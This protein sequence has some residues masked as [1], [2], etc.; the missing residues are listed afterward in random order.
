MDLKSCLLVAPADDIHALAVARQISRVSNG[1]VRPVFL[2]IATFPVGSRISLRFGFHGERSHQLTL[3]RPLP[4]VYGPGAAAALDEW[5]REGL[6]ALSSEQVCGIWWRRPRRPVLS[7]AVTAPELQ[8]YARVNTTT[9]IRALIAIL[10]EDVPVIN[11]PVVEA[12]AVNKPYQL[13]AAERIDLAIPETLISHDENEI[14]AFIEHVEA[15]GGEV[16]LKPVVTMQE[17]AQS[18]QRLDRNLREHLNAARLCPTIF[19][20]FIEGLDLRITVVGDQVFAMAE[21]H[22]GECDPVD[23]RLDFHAFRRAF[24]LPPEYREKILALHR[25]LNLLFGAYDCKLDGDGMLWFLEVNP[26]GQWLWAEVEAQLPISE[27]LARALCFG[28]DSDISAQF[29]PLSEA[30]VTSLRGEPLNL[31]YARAMKSRMLQ[32]EL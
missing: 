21:E 16:I 14:R 13:R 8:S 30:D 9:V 1:Q 19:Q 17:A 11:P 5:A 18:T 12:R 29:S 20:R 28:M 26:S 7:D 10:S 32:N 31:V 6:T 15:R 24:D 23:I 22:S 3:T 4:S 27:C 2:D 25:S